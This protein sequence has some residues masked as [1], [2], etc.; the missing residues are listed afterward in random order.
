M[1]AGKTKASGNAQ[2]ADADKLL[3]RVLRPLEH[4]GQRL[5]FGD[6]VLLDGAASAA[7][8]ACTPIVIEPAEDTAA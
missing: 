2:A 4:D 8:L 5:A 3:Y 6:T 1:A 7:L